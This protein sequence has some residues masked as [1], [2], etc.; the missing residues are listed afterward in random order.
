MNLGNGQIVI[1]KRRGIKFW[2]MTG[3]L[4][5]IGIGIL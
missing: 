2:A 4:E 3:I 5:R 1:P